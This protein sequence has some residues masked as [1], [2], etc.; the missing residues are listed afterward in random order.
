ML[1]DDLL[2]GCE[3][4]VGSLGVRTPVLAVGKRCRACDMGKC[5]KDEKVCPSM[6]GKLACENLGA[7]TDGTGARRASEAS[8]VDRPS[9]RA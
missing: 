6:G 5:P 9:A 4:E 7:V 8:S 1:S 2:H 3:A